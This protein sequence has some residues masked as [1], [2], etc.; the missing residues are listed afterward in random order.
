MKAFE[1]LEASLHL[2]DPKDAHV[3]AAAIRAAAQAIVT[4]TI[5]DFPD[6]V[7]ER[8][9]VEA[10]HPDEFV[11]D[12]IDLAPAIIVQC[13]TQ[14]AAACRNPAVT[15]EQLLDILRSAGLAQS[16]ARFHELLHSD[17]AG[18]ST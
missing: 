8:Y 13:L 11:L 1:H 4:F 17:S 5:K 9:E 6:H 14:Q 18:L 7:L 15:V 2:P 3:L 12:S 16:V 10:K